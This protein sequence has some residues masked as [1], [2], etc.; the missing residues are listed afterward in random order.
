MEVDYYLNLNTGGNIENNDERDSSLL[1]ISYN[2]AQ[3]Y[4]IN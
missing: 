1:D 3:L 4:K 2:K